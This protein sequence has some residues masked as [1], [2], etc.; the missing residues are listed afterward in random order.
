MQVVESGDLMGQQYLDGVDGFGGRA[1][2]LKALDE[3]SLLK[4]PGLIVSDIV[5]LACENLWNTIRQKV[6]LRYSLSSSQMKFL[7]NWVNTN[8]QSLSQIIES[9]DE[10]GQAAKD[11]QAAPSRKQLTQGHM[12]LEQRMAKQ[13][14]GWLA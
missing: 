9:A 7:L 10:E 6:L 2:S 13:L 14:A 11:E 3:Q 8:L 12:A 5:K 4:N 1:R